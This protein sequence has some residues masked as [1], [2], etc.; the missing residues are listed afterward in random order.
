M[1]QEIYFVSKIFCTYYFTNQLYTHCH[2]HVKLRYLV[3]LFLRL[4]K[5]YF[6][7][8]QGEL[9]KNPQ[10]FR[11]FARQYTN[12]LHWLVFGSIKIPL[13]GQLIILQLQTISGQ[14]QNNCRHLR[15]LNLI[16]PFI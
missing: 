3:Q 16:S 4:K 12:I 11:N 1:K 2:W 15:S 7:K 5:E 14:K 13:Q 9:Y 8:K 6:H 10:K